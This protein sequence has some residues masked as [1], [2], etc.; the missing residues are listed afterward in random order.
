MKATSGALR[1]LG[2]ETVLFACGSDMRMGVPLELKADSWTV[3]G[4]RLDT[5]KDWKLK[6]KFNGVFVN[7]PIE[8]LRRAGEA[9]DA[10]IYE[11]K[12]REE[13]S[14]DALA[15][16]L[17]QEIAGLE[18]KQ[19]AWNRRKEVRW[20]IGANEREIELFGFKRAEQSLVAK[21]AEK[22]CVV[23]NL[24]FSGAQVIAWADG[25]ETGEDVGLCLS[26]KN[27]I[28]FL[29]TKS[30]VVSSESVKVDGSRTVAIVSMRHLECPVEYHE[31]LEAFAAKK[32][33]LAAAGR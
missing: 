5:T 26:L 17:R 22:P 3:A 25:Y 14:I 31:R 28:Q 15:F 18:K 2:I 10:V 13:K 29:V 4:E 12:V 19:G 6:V 20:E 1:A 33:A 30:K 8:E 32:E 27:P 23:N 21:S 9:G 11:A 24:S 16:C 7:M